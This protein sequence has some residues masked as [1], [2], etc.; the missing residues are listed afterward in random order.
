M[1]VGLADLIASKLAPTKELQV[2]TNIV[3]AEDPMWERACS[4]WR[5]F[6]HMDV[7]LAGLIAS[8]LA[9]TGETRSH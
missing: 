2:H 4:R 6:S 9:P 8:R 5:W 7:G 3:S 1:Y